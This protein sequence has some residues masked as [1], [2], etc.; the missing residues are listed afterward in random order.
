MRA[1]SFSSPLKIFFLSFETLRAEKPYFSAS[2][3][4]DASVIIISKDSAA[5]RIVFSRPLAFLAAVFAA[6]DFAELFFIF[7]KR[8]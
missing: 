2:A 5:R 6:R 1:A 8:V 4:E 3:A 7:E